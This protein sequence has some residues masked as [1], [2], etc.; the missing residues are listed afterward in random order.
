MTSVTAV[1][2]SSVALFHLMPFLALSTTY[3]PLYPR[4][5]DFLTSLLV[6]VIPF[7][8]G[9]FNARELGA[10]ICACRKKLALGLELGELQASAVELE[11]VDLLGW[12]GLWVCCRRGLDVRR[13]FSL[14]RM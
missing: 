14:L 11:Y 9:Q 5:T 10:G 3:L 13:V 7:A 1:K 12:V 8:V 4:D 6:V 2:G